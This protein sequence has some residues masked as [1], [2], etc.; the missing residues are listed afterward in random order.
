M[1][2]K[3]L[4]EQAAGDYIVRFTTMV[5]NRFDSKA[6]KGTYGELYSRYLKEMTSKRFSIVTA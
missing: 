2:S 3:G 1:E 4:E 6:F 5:S